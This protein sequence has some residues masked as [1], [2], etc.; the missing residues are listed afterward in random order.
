MAKV[1]KREIKRVN[2]LWEIEHGIQ[3]KGYELIAGIDESG[4][5]PL[6]G[7]V[8]AAACILPKDFFI[9]GIDDSKVLDFEQRE[10]IFQELTNNPNIFFGVHVVDSSIIDQINI[11][12]ASLLAMKMAVQKLS[13][14]PNF[15]IFDGNHHPI[16]AIPSQAI[17]D[18]DALS[19]S[20]AAASIIAKQTRDRIM[21]EY[22]EKWPQY[23]FKS[24]KGY[25][26]EEHRKAIF[27]HGICAIH[28]KSFEPI[29]S[30]LS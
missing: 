15:L 18:G 17:I 10:E 7:P 6:A 4:R 2:K 13:I 1:G 22:H 23:D 16:T 19:I 26:T 29:K 30:M 8:V 12:Q 25:G 20:I 5:G 24:H 9:K 27:E 3:E 28:R 11:F 14:Q 21:I